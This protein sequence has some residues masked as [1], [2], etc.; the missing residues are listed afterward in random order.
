M[1]W[2]VNPNGI[3]ER[4]AG[5]YPWSVSP[6]ADL[7]ADNGDP[8][9]ALIYAVSALAVTPDGSIFVARYG[10]NHLPIIYTIPG[11]SS[12]QGIMTPIGGQ[13][14]PSEDGAEVYVFGPDG[15]HLGTLDSVT[16]AAKWTF[17]YDTNSLVVTMTDLSGK[18]TR[19]ERDASGQATAIVGPYGQRTSLAMDA[20][21]FLSA[22]TNPAHET[23]SLSNSTGGL[24]LSITG[25]LGDA[26]RIAYDEVGRAIQV[27]DPIGGGWTTSLV[28]Q[29][30]RA[31]YS[32]ETDVNCTNSL[33]HTLSRQMVLQPNGDTSVDSSHDGYAPDTATRRVSGDTSTF[34]GDGSVVFT[35]AGADPRFGNQAQQTAA[36]TVRFPNGLTYNETLLRSVGLANTSD[37]FS[38]TGLTNVT[39]VNSNRYTM[40]YNPTNRTTIYTSPEGRTV[41]EVHDALGRVIRQSMPGSSV[42][43]VVYDSFGRVMAVTNTSSLGVATTL[44]AYDA[45]GQLSMVVDPLGRT[46]A[47]GYDAAGRLNRQVLPDGASA[48]LV[49]DSNG[50]LTSVA[51]PGRPAH[52]FQYDAAGLMTRYSPPLLG[53]DESVNYQHDTERNLTS[54]SFPD[55]Q[56]LGLQYG[57][58]GRLE[59]AT[60]GDGPT[61]TYGYGTNLG[62]GYLLP[63]T[64]SSSSGE[65]VQLRYLASIL[66]NVSWSGSVT[67]R[68]SAE[69]NSD[70]LPV[71]QSVDGSTVSYQYNHDRLVIQAGA[72]SILRDPFSGL[73]TETF[74][75]GVT[76]Q[77]Q[78]DDQ[79]GMTNYSA[80]VNGRP[81]W[82]FMLGYDLA[83]RIITK[84]ECIGGSTNTFGYGYDVI[85]RL[86][87][88]W[89]NGVLSTTYTYDANG[90]R[91][92]R[93]GETATYDSQDRLRSRAGATYNWSPNGH[94][95]SVVSGGE[96]T[97]YSYD[98][99]GGLT[100]VASAG[101][102]AISYVVD[103]WGRRI[104]KKVGGALQRGWLW[105]WSLRADPVPTAEL[106]G[107]SGLTLRFVWGS[108]AT[109]PAYFVAGA[110][111]YRIFCD[112]RGSVR[113][114]VNVAEGTI[115]QQIDYDEF[116]QVVSDTAPGFQPF[117]FAGGLYD[118]DT[119]LV[120]FGARDY[121]PALGR[122]TDR[123]PSRFGSGSYNLYAYCDN[124]PVN[125]VDV[126]GAGAIGAAVRSVQDDMFLFLGGIWIA[127]S[128]LRWRNGW[129]KGRLPCTE[130]TANR[131]TRTAT[132]KS[133]T[134]SSRSW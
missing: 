90:N 43:D 96:T 13:N 57:L 3:V 89:R 68:V 85:G 107:H 15:R 98:V 126:D 134:R 41:S 122:W 8:L 73:V 61:L 78:F 62:S 93:N 92:S 39:T 53:T 105:D 52:S 74:L 87:Q 7:P 125:R 25:P 130:R 56:V 97:T 116:G 114:V 20:N 127:W 100:G 9:N 54:V 4:V 14:I 26:D 79:G 88:V 117:G 24:V 75:E 2:R 101:A 124:D 19:I 48:N 112:E 84:V 113:L 58:A 71:F 95:Q 81:I 82:S 40:G 5:R 65:S 12:Q 37:P 28:D 18:V 47:F 80:S 91:L 49:Y 60:L 35:G 72:L 133:T 132:S 6:P 51:P 1:V 34:Y 21:G 111:T 131:A 38:L 42:M 31:D 123:D 69:L 77:S 104:G 50:R 55:G 99:R 66:T 110:D 64:V 128:C 32:Y 63:A 17:G 83:G 120:R 103:A 106:D 94:L 119:G 118:P 22:V 23:T 70:L 108:D 76:D 86:A 59:Q 44:S 16:G 109:T 33:G 29:G 46:N 67:G 10:N 27:T 36:L 115:A 102:P 129:R 45:L 11:R 30:V 121:D